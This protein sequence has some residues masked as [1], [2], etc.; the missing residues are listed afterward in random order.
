MIIETIV[1][2]ILG[3]MFGI[4]TGLIPGIHTNLISSV[5][6]TFLPILLEFSSPITLV[7][8]IVSMSIS[9]IFLDFIPTTFLGA[10]DEDTTLSM[11]PTHELL[12]DGKAQTAIFL[13]SLGAI[14]GTLLVFITTPILM[15]SLETIY[16]FFEMMMPWILIWVA[17]ILI[18]GEKQL[19]T[20][21]L[22]FILSGFFGIASLN[23]NLNQPLLP[24]LTGL[25]GISGLIFSVNQKTK[26]P[27]QE[28][29]IYFP[30]IKEI[31]KPALV[32]LII[33]PFCSF[34]PGL[35]GSQATIISSKILG[36]LN[37][38]QFLIMN[39][40]VNTILMGLSFTVL[41]VIQKSRTG[42][43]ATIS[44]II[45][46]TKPQIYLILIIILIVAIISFFLT[47]YLSKKISQHI[48]KIN[49]KVTSISVIVFLTI[50]VFI[51]SGLIG[52]IVLII[53]TTLGLT[54]QYYGI[55]KGILM[56]CLLIPTI[57]YYLPF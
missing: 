33:S 12:L 13:S 18:K 30:E 27:P 51:L 52:L 25:F 39:G 26:I 34:L 31:A 44:E 47:L 29:K 36:Q 43:A 14:I 32:S 17:I 45:D 9:T 5:L 46:I 53:S 1:A 49:Y 57:L 54:C 28:T 7:I 24:M 21:I 19:S 55:R 6:I 48:D 35:G 23:L 8:F 2:I 11:M 10:P 41:F 37:R 20:T 40:I 56:G 38:K 4:I 22:I 3:I 50:L 16:P 15:F 42:S